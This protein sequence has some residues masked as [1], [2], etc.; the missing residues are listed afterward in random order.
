MPRFVLATAPAAAVPLAWLLPN[1]YPPW[2][3]A[4]QDGWAL[5]TLA[6]AAM[7]CQRRF[8]VPAL[9][10]AALLVAL[11]A[12]AVQS[13]TGLMTYGGDALMAGWYV[14]AFGVAIAVGIG[15]AGSS[16]VQARDSFIVAL[17]GGT[18]VGAVASTAIALMQWAGV[19]AFGMWVVDLPPSGRP[20][21]NVAQPNHYSTIAFLGICAAALLREMGQLRT[22]VFVAIAASLLWGMAVSGSRTGWLQI[23]AL[24]ALAWYCGSRIPLKTGARRI[25]WLAAVF[26]LFVVA[27]PLLAEHADLGPARAVGEQL[28]AGKRPP[29]WLAMVDAVWQ[30]PWTGYG[31]QQVSAAQQAVATRHPPVGAHFEHSHNVV[32]DLLV[33]NGLGVGSLILLLGAA[34]LLRLY[35]GVREP[36]AVWLLAAVSGL[37]IHANL[38][39]PLEYAYFLVP[40]GLFIGAIHA[41]NTIETE[42][43]WPAPLLPMAGVG[44]AAVLS[45][46][47]VDYLEAE[48]NHRILRLE[49][50][51]IGVRAIETPAP[52]LR[53]LDQLQA[54]LEFART[55]AR[56]NMT[57][58][59]LQAM[60]RVAERFG[61][62]PVLLRYALAAGLN[63]E[64][65]TAAL[66]LERLC[67]IHPRPRC[68][69]GRIAWVSLGERYPALR[70]IRYPS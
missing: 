24:L 43:K 1:H 3:S 16:N 64:P 39:F 4:W 36:R 50:A 15:W 37:L 62:P 47:A 12:I 10:S 26:A 22:S 23:F 30:R 66:T 63:G 20:F 7:C 59:D 40:M 35:A 5:A 33:W 45:V 8:D 2:T 67:L 44:L 19:T 25:A 41:L 34:A 17:A 51:R 58:E 56:P 70:A 48:Q 38:E 46:V 54:F 49:S 28:Q 65:A 9:W 11:G 29:L 14:V 52:T 27:W 60:R 61:Y 57:A 31:W 21:A 6:L 53:V 68:D 42:P 18:V 69:E 32:L 13:M 55:E